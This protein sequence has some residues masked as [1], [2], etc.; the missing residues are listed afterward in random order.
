MPR[1]PVGDVNHFLK[2]RSFE[3]G[4]KLLN[5]AHEAA[6]RLYCDVLQFWRSCEEP[7]CRRHRGCA[8]DPHDCLMRGMIFVP[9]RKRLRARR[10]VIG[11]G[12]R[13]RKPSSHMEWQVRRADFKS[14]ASWPE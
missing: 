11:G 10:D 2:R 6:Q 8:G 5:A 7:R 1:F 12:P 3:E 4:M 13:R 9:Q 14:V